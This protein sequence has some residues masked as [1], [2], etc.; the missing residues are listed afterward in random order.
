MIEAS[1]AMQYGIRLK[2]EDLS[3]SEFNTL[4]AGM[5]P[6]TPLGQIVQIRSESDPKVLKHF[7]KEQ[8][9]I[10]SE[11]RRK[12]AKKQISSMSEKDK[13]TAVNSIND[14]FRSMFMN[15]SKI[16]GSGVVKK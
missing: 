13:R 4:L 12:M 15:D 6:D 1:F 14:M 9:R 8:N 16:Q 2:Q 7:N 3:I 10:R 11:W 5:M